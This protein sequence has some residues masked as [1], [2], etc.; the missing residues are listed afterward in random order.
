MSLDG[1]PTQ[2]VDLV[3]AASVLPP[4]LVPRPV[5]G[6][7]WRGAVVAR[8]IIVLALVGVL[9]GA[10]W[11]F[12]A[13]AVNGVVVLSRDGSE[14]AHLYLGNDGDHFFTSAAMLMGMLSVIGVVSAV[15]MWQWRAQRGPA[16]V[17]AGLIGSV[18]AAVTAT[19]VGAGLVRLRYGAVDVANAPVT[20]ADRFHYVTE[21]PAVFLSHHPLVIAATL[22]AGAAVWCAVYLVFTAATSRDDLGGQPS[23]DPGWTP[24]APVAGPPPQ[25]LPSH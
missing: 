5:V 25:N 16:M 17:L 10:L 9:V 4:P 8:V 15:A 24:F 2:P 21:A 18:A 1:E 14:R 23:S 20:Q 11:S 12:V 3:K 22:L 7:L 6:P 19:A 13:P